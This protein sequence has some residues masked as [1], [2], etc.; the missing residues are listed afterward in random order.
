M[1]ADMSGL[2]DQG[3][4]PDA[5]ELCTLARAAE[6]LDSRLKIPSDSGDQRVAFAAA[7]T[8]TAGIAITMGELGK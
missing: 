1:I 4:R 5:T 8:R 7:G 3:T 6:A 2:C